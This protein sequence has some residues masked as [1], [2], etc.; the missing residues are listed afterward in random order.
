[1]K[2]EPED[3]NKQ[4][5]LQNNLRGDDLCTNCFAKYYEGGDDLCTTELVF[6]A[7]HQNWWCDET[8]S[9]GTNVLS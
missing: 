4:F 9:W 8:N 5:F 2:S 6:T 1:M 3:K 7:P